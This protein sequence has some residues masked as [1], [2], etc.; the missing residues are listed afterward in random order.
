MNIAFGGSSGGARRWVAF[1]VESRAMPRRPEP[2]GGAPIGET[3]R[4]SALAGDRA[5]RPPR[6]IG[7]AVPTT[8]RSVRTLR[9][10]RGLREEHLPPA[11]LLRVPKRAARRRGLERPPGRDRYGRRRAAP[12]VWDGRG[13]L[14]V[15]VVGVGAVLGELPP[16]RLG[17]R[18]RRVA[19]P[20]EIAAAQI[21]NATRGEHRRSRRGR[22][23]APRD[24]HE[25]P[26]E[27]QR[28]PP[29]VTGA[30]RQGTK[31]RVSRRE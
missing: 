28:R 8:A 20:R 21:A 22:A 26:S 25:R 7:K 16:A 30:R 23:L 14:V 24:A 4:L 18:R 1:T 9:Q 17:P 13:G 2:Q 3:A 29:P 27:L 12:S 10:R 5:N 15:V 11:G 19:F 31:A 6:S